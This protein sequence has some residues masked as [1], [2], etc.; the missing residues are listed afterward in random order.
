MVIWI[1]FTHSSPLIPK[2]SMFTLTHLFNH[3]QFTL[4][5]G[6]KIPG[7]Y[8]ILFFMELNFTFTTRYIHSW[9]MLPLCLSLFIPSGA[10]SLL[11]SNSI[12]DT[13]WPVGFI[14]QCHISLPFHSVYGI[15]KPRRQTW[16]E[17][18]F[19]SGSHFIRTLHHD[20]S[21]LGGP[22]WHGS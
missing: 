17:T 20:P 10:T 22:A 3:I 14:F 1:K 19:S 5:H 2:I 6:P 12:L 9:A 15:L 11:L 18:P 21:I 8:A 7:S 4:I 16:F 13:C